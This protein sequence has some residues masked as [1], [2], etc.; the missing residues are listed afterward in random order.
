MK[1]FL[2]T[3]LLLLSACSIPL[4]KQQH[5]V[6]GAV[7]SGIAYLATDDPRAAWA[8]AAAMGAAKEAY[9]ATG[10]GQVEAEDFLAT[11]AGAAI[12]QAV[13]CLRYD[14]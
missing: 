5:F 2:L 3:S 6:A 1:A 14:C 8:T 4:D 12:W 9:D 11:V 10:R 13:H 7:G